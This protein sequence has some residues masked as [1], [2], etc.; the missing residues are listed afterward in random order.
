MFLYE[1]WEGK[2]ELNPKQKLEQGK[3]YIVDDVF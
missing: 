1:D 3:H 2:V